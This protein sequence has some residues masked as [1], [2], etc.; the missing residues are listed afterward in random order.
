MPGPEVNVT[1]P[2]AQNVVGPPGVIAG[3]AGSGFTVTEI[4]LLDELWHPEPFTICT[5]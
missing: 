5:E 4:T 3:V 2:P 1:D